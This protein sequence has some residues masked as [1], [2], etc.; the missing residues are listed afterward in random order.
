MTQRGNAIK[1]IYHLHFPREGDM[2][3]SHGAPGGSTRFGQEAEGKGG[4]C[5]QKTLVW[6]L[7]EGVDEA[8]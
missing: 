1:R 4:R 2:P 3:S 7:Q 8:G 6:S 5:E